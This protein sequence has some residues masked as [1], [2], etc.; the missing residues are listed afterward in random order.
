MLAAPALAGPNASWVAFP[1]N[2]PLNTPVALSSATG[3][4]VDVTITTGGSRGVHGAA[5]DTLGV[6]ATGLVYDSLCVVAIYNGGG[7]GHVTTTLVFSNPRVGPGHDRGLFVVG[8]VNG[9]SSP[10]TLTST[11]P[12][13]VATFTVVGSPFA[14]G[15]Q[16]NYEISWVPVLGQFQTGAPI[17]IDSRCVVL[18][19]GDLRTAG[20]LTVTLSQYLNDGIVF[21]FGEKLASALAVPP[22][23]PTRVAL[24]APRPSPARESTVLA[25]ATSVA[26]RAR[27][28]V[29]DVSGRHVATLL[30]DDLG[31][32]RHE[33]TWDLRA[34]DG[35][36]VAP[37]LL[38]VRLQTAEGTRTTRLMVMR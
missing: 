10:V 20:S 12:G 15:A 19:L 16:N 30:D 26:G 5:N 24:D 2:V 11:V 27:L 25:F 4:L 38:F 18:D 8:A 22:V 9:L 13:R 33:R 7:S 35:T 34:D 32:G 23:P 37:G 1:A 6:A 31:P 21:G 28:E 14:Y 36:R 17:G 3:L 29:L